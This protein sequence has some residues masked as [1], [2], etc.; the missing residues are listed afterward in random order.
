MLDDHN[1]TTMSWYWILCVGSK[2]RNSKNVSD[3]RK[4]RVWIIKPNLLTASTLNA[5]EPTNK[6]SAHRDS[7]Y[8]ITLKIWANAALSLSAIVT[9]CSDESLK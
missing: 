2:D 1:C 3:G 4:K 6:G 5:E 8:N 7:L 9:E